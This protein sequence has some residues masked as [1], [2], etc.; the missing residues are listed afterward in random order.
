MVGNGATLVMGDE[1]ED[2][3]HHESEGGRAGEE[4][5]GWGEG[6]GAADEEVECAGE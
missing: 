2:L 6:E 3:W 5:R 4:V 1:R